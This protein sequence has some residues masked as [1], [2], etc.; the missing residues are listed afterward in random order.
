MGTI[1]LQR[2]THVS[3]ENTGDDDDGGENDGLEN[4]DGV[5]NGGV[6]VCVLLDANKQ[7][8]ATRETAYPKF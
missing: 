3:W 4:G 5:E 2:N 1:T 8:Q 7:N 6:F